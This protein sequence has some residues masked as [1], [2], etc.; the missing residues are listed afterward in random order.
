M[1]SLQISEDVNVVF[2]TP[3]L[4]REVPKSEIA[5]AQLATRIRDVRDAAPGVVLS[6]RGGWQSAPDLWTWQGFGFD[7]FRDAVDDAVRRMAALTSQET[8][9]T[10]VDVRY[11]AAAWANVNTRGH[12]NTKHIH[13]GMHW[14][15]VY[16]VTGASPAGASP[17]GASPAGADTAGADAADPGVE[18]SGRLELFDPRPL[19]LTARQ[20][21]FG[22]GRGLSIEPKPG[23]LV[24]FPAWIEHFVHPFFGAGER[25][26]IAVNVRLTG[27]RH[28]G[29]A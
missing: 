29:I 13:P 20:P 1:L 3:V 4:R 6:N 26:S 11:E 27:G 9:L 25:I 17:A 15:I 18:E 19:A 8:D 7:W 5:N 16:Y 10:K 21:A 23:T 24:M 2:G 22:F 14:S 28:A 12:Y